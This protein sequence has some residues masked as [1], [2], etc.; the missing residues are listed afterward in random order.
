M[1]SIPIGQLANYTAADRKPNLIY[2]GNFSPGDNLGFI[3]S[4]EAVNGAQQVTLTGT[5]DGTNRVFTVP[6][7]IPNH[8]QIY[9]N[10]VLQDPAL[11]Y[12][13]SGTTVTFNVGVVPQVGD[14]LQAVV[15]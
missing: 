8:A 15:S 5:V 10:G 12:A 3:A 13:I 9:R 7:T 4:S 14:D 11:S 6:I 2:F 1:A